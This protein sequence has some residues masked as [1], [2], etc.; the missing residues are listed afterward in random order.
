MRER[1]SNYSNFKFYK[2]IIIKFVYCM[3]SIIILYKYQMAIKILRTVQR[4]IH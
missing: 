2:K 3:I 4:S 1:F